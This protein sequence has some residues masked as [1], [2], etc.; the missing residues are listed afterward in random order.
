MG[1]WCNCRI[2]QDQRKQTGS[3]LF[4]HLNIAGCSRIPRER[5][6]LIVG[7]YFSNLL[8]PTS[9]GIKNQWY[10]QKFCEEFFCICMST[11]RLLKRE[12]VSQKACISAENL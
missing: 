4:A 1:T 6:N 12:T 9:G 3:Y 11:M 5:V 2:N 7:H 8:Y 10:I